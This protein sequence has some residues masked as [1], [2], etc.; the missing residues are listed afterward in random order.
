M[1]AKKKKI[2]ETTTTLNSIEASN[3]RNHLNTEPSEI[4]VYFICYYLSFFSLWISKAFFIHFYSRRNKQANQQPNDLWICV[5]VFLINFFFFG[6]MK[7]RNKEELE[8]VS[9]FELIW[10]IKKSILWGFLLQR[11]N[12]SHFGTKWKL[13]QVF[14]ISVEVAKKKTPFIDYRALYLANYW[15]EMI[16]N[17]IDIRENRLPSEPYI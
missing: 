11:R 12:T 17:S 16:D 4:L 3:K 9:N 8:N 2:T 1:F 14:W 10:L 7:V 6:R 5:G 13:K 15:N